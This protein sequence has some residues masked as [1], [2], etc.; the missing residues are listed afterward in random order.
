MFLSYFPSKLT[1]SG[2]E[3]MSSSQ[4]RGIRGGRRQEESRLVDG[5]I[6]RKDGFLRHVNIFDTN[7]GPDPAFISRRKRGIRKHL[8]HPLKEPD[9][10]P[11]GQEIGKCKNLAV[12]R[13]DFEAWMFRFSRSRVQCSPSF[14]PRRSTP[15]TEV[16][17]EFRCAA[18]GGEEIPLMF[19]VQTHDSANDHE[20]EYREPFDVCLE[21]SNIWFN[22]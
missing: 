17:N 8:R 12:L 15:S 1:P 20:H 14:P 5:G 21:G 9:V 7:I 4:R 3:L 18:N 19:K 6:E 11:A 16:S 13:A 10:I 2:L 22:V